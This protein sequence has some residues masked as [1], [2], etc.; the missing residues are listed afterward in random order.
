MSDWQFG[1]GIAASDDE[2]RL[3][4]GAAFGG[5]QVQFKIIKGGHIVVEDPQTKGLMPYIGGRVTIDPVSKEALVV[6]TNVASDKA[7]QGK[8]RSRF[9]QL[10]HDHRLELAAMINKQTLEPL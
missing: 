1:P 5:I 6:F 4:P 9:D 2:L 10:M 3:S 7:P 8:P